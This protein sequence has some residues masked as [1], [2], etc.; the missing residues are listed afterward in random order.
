MSDFDENG[1][2]IPDHDEI[3]D[4][5]EDRRARS[6]SQGCLCGYPDLPGQCP[7]PRNCPMHGQDLS[8]GDDA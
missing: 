4:A 7:G 6:L 2:R 3:R 8:E 1:R 5:H